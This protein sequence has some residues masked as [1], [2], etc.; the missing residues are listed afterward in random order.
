MT[1]HQYSP[2]DP[3]PA[4]PAGGRVPFSIEG[5]FLLIALVLAAGGAFGHWVQY[6]KQDRL[7]VLPDRV[8]VILTLVLDHGDETGPLRERFDR[9][10]SGGLEEEERRELEE[11]LSALILKDLRIQCNGAVPELRRTA[12]S[13]SGSDGPVRGHERIEGTVVLEAPLP[14][15]EALEIL[16]ADR[17]TAGRRQVPVS[18]VLDG[19][20]CR[21]CPGATAVPRRRGGT[22]LS[23]ISLTEGRSWTGRFVR[24][25]S[26]GTPETAHG[27]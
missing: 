6:P 4:A 14:S 16:V 21:D 18:V 7:E 8:R 24:A 19:W 22:E 27:R 23:G 3:P 9:D 11:H 20:E 10:G 25:A 17:T 15:G 5:L 26:R 13:S 12:L 1:A 2:L